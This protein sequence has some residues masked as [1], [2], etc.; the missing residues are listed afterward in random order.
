MASKLIHGHLYLLIAGSA[1][2][3]FYIGFALDG[4]PATTPGIEVFEIGVGIFATS[5][6][7]KIAAYKTLGLPW[8]GRVKKYS[9]EEIQRQNEL[10]ARTKKELDEN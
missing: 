4:D 7:L 5:W 2:I 10:L 8:H 1:L 9:P 3:L 6:L